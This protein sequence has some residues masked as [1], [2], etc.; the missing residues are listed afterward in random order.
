MRM[1]KWALHV[2]TA[3]MLPCASYAH[4]TSSLFCSQLRL[5]TGEG[6]AVLLQ[7]QA[8]IGQMGP[9]ILLLRCLGSLLLLLLTACSCMLGATD[10][11]IWP[12]LLCICE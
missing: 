5:S 3:Y 6:Q 8:C 7:E 9:I 10:I 4:L 2:M 1:P 11:W 12:L